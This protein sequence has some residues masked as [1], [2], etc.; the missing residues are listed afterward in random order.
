MKGMILL[1]EL[2]LPVVTLPEPLLQLFKTEKVKVYEHNGTVQLVPINESSDAYSLYGMF[3][4]SN[5][6]GEQFLQWKRDDALLE[7]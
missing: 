7:S 1:P 4:D 5:L 2:I 6:T 3:A